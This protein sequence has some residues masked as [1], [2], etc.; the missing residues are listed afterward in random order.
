MHV[1]GMVAGFMDGW[2]N[3]GVVGWIDIEWIHV[4]YGCC[5]AQGYKQIKV[6]TFC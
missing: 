2:V 4:V 3:A 1:G 6:E 5:V